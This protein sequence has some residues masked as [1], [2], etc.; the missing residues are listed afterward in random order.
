MLTLHI[1]FE[2]FMRATEVET[3]DDERWPR[4]GVLREGGGGEREGRVERSYS[5]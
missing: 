3:S 4:I 5:R 2:S 1:C